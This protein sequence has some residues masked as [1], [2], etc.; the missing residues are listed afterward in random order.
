V[1]ILQGPES[2]CF[3]GN[4]AESGKSKKTKEPKLEEQ[5]E[6]LEKV[7]S[8]LESGDASLEKSI[9]LYE[10]GTK[11]GKNCLKQLE[12]LEQKVNLIR[13]NEHGDLEQTP[14]DDD[15]SE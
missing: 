3:D 5:I 1:D 9:A 8:E 2:F 14:F 12:T 15:Q 10:E 13:E 11:L 4:M 6:R 7:V